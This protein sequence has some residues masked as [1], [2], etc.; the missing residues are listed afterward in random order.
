MSDSEP[1]S[2]SWGATSREVCFKLADDHGSTAAILDVD[3]EA[4]VAGIRTNPPQEESR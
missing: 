1:S 4:I 3:V 2:S